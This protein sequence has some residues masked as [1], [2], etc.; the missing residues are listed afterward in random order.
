[1]IT[2][3]PRFEDP[4]NSFYR[5][6]LRASLLRIYGFVVR[7]F[8]S[9]YPREWRSRDYVSDRESL[10]SVSASF[11]HRFRAR[12]ERTPRPEAVMVAS[13]RYNVKKKS[14][15]RKRDGGRISWL[16][17]KGTYYQVLTAYTAHVLPISMVF[18][19]TGNWCLFESLPFRNLSHE[20]QVVVSK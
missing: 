11:S 19:R 9:H 17:Y 5:S 3:S 6:R 12:I 16:S 8:K 1:M 14:I 4:E 7:K 20:D 15:T 2:P 10:S 18:V 13:S